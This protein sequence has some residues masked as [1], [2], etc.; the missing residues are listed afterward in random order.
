MLQ[1]SFTITPDSES[2]DYAK[3][4]L[5]PLEKGY[6]QTLGVSLRRVLLTSIEGAAITSV[7]LEGVHHQFTTLAGMKEDVVNFVL[8]LK[9]LHFSIAVESEE[10]TAKLEAK[11]PGTVTGR[12]LQ[13]PA[14]VSLANPDQVLATLADSKAKLAAEVVISQGRGYSLA[15]DRPIPGLGEIPV[16]AAFSPV[17]KVAYKVE[18]T[19]VGRRTDF[20]KLVMEI[21]TDGTIS[22]RNAL[23]KA[24]KILVAQFKQ[25]FDPVVVA[26][27]KE[28]PLEGRLED[29]VYR[30]TV[31]ELDLP[32]RIANALRKGGYKTVRDLVNAKRADIAKVKNLGEKSVEVVADA[33]AQKNLTLFDMDGE[34]SSGTDE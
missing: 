6:G 2:G 10:V 31:E 4:S 30:L 20:D 33:L 24:A 9:Q 18:T 23:E 5:E 8:N 11:G 1:P 28:L 19:R 34:I 29:E 32:T 25:V 15:S 21:W 3:L 13:L 22:P 26:V 17:V 14:G 7:R 16:D 27:P 12:D